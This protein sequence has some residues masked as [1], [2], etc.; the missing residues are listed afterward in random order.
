M[1][2]YTTITQWKI[3]FISL[4]HAL[5]R[6]LLWYR[7]RHA[8]RDE[9]YQLSQMD[10]TDIDFPESSYW[11]TYRSATEPSGISS[12]DGVTYNFHIMMQTNKVALNV[13]QMAIVLPVACIFVR[14]S[15]KIF[16]LIM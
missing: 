15:T 10:E 16:L 2:N 8:H 4:R 1:P 14:A 11:I 5:E 9:G 12:D 7:G 6:C 3:E 13:N